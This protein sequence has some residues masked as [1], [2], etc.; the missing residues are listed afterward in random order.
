[1]LSSI[2]GLGAEA[3]QRLIRLTSDEQRV[4]DA[5]E[6]VSSNR[7]M[8]KRWVAAKRIQLA[9]GLSKKSTR[10]KLADMAVRGI[11]EEAG[12]MWRVVR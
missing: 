3:V 6:W 4:L 2:A 7:Q 12:G 8:Y 1:M 10:Q 9:L 11:L 5:F